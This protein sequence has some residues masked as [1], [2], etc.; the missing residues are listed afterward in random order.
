VVLQVADLATSSKVIIDLATRLK[1]F[2]LYVAVVVFKQPGRV[3]DLMAYQTL[4][5]KA[6]QTYWWP[7]WVVYD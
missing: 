5:A 7:S 6:S 1:C 2:G 3:V 4:I